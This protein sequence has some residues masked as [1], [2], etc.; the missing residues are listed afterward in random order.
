MIGYCTGFLDAVSGVR[1]MPEVAQLYTDVMHAD[2]N[3]HHI[4]G[5]AARFLEALHD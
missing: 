4:V 5:S 2:K 1:H 3:T